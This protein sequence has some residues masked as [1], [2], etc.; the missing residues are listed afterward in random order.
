MIAIRGI[1]SFLF[2]NVLRTVLQLKII[3][4][5]QLL[6]KIKFVLK[7]RKKYLNVLFGNMLMWE[8]Q[9]FDFLIDYGSVESLNFKAENVVLQKVL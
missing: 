1:F 9:K 2:V 7:A 8:I 6:I 3:Y 4:K 5:P